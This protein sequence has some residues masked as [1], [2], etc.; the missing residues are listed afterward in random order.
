MSQHLKRPNGLTSAD[1]FEEYLL[2]ALCS[3]Q[4]CCVVAATSSEEET[5]ST[6][7]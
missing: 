5:Q 1:S 3:S 2:S 7:G 6:F 4:E